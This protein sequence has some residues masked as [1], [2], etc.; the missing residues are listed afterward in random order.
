MPAC[1][2]HPDRE[3]AVSCSSC[4]RPI[5]PDCMTPS[6]VGMRCPECAGDRTKVIHARQIAEPRLFDVAPV[7]TVLIAINVIAYLAEI[8]TGS[9][10]SGIS[11][12]TSG[13]VLNH[14]V[15][16]GP[17][18]A[19]GEWWRI[20]TSG[21]LHLGF[22]HIGMNMLLLFLLGR[23]L[24]P[25]IGSVRFAGIYFFSLVAGSLGSLLLEPTVSAAGASGAV[26][27]LMSA[28]LIAQRTRGINPWESGIGGLIV[29]NLLLTFAVPGIAKGGHLGGLVGGLVM[30]FVLIDLDE[31]RKLFGRSIVPAAVIGIV[32]TI[33][34]FALTVVVAQNKFPAIAAL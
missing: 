33:A 22:I 28:A 10:T 26:F 14:G 18:V 6:P 12:G 4:G 34:L 17:L 27:G 20:V 30:A 15:F 3:T 9:G 19:D 8:L 24:E 31:T 13:S 23:Q 11:R 7:T 2:R 29:L 5:C 32:G 25:A 16:F 21:F 1:Y